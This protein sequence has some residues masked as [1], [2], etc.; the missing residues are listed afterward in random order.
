MRRLPLVLLLMAGALV[1][2]PG[3]ALAGAVRAAA[4]PPV[5]TSLPTIAGVVK[6]G[7]SLTAANG[8]WT[9]LAPIA[10]SYQWQ[11]CSTSGG[12]C[13]SIAKATNQNYV[14]SKDDVGKT[15]R[16]QVTGTN[17]DGKSQALSVATA[18]IAV[19]GN[20]PANTKQPNPSGNAT[21][22]K[23]IKVDNGNWSG[24]N[25]ITFSYQWQACT[26]V[27]GACK[28]I[29]GVTG[30]SFKIGAAQIGMLLR[31]T[32]TA[33][34]SAGKGSASSNLTLAVIAKANAPVNTTLPTISGL[35][36]VGRTLHL[37]T[38]N[39]TGVSANGFSYQWSRC[40]ADGTGCA[41]V[42]GATGQ[43]YGVR[44]A[45][46]RMAIR[47]VVTATNRNGSMS[48][49]S[50]ASV[51]TG[52]LANL[53]FKF[54]SV[55]RSGHEVKGPHGTSTRAAGHFSA[56]VTGQ[57]LTWT[58]RFHHLTGRPTVT[59][60]NKGVRHANGPAFKSLCRYRHCASPRHGTLRLTASQLDAMKRGR[61]YV[62]IHTMKNRPGEIRGQ[63]L[64]VR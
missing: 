3:S 46:F 17:A 51:I 2:L 27:P 41:N 44:Q 32:V 9:G 12:S 24:L 28:D 64:M 58:L 59:T 18:S 61:A 16:V 45:D 1:V 14:A 22:G 30:S 52:G 57:T 20:A 6:Q 33:T 25:P 63:I 34:N 42:F 49:Q 21:E 38:G 13:G 5:N 8:T 31:A 62:N 48:A 4:S 10:Y 29:D 43:N 56:K 19:N 36:A 7:E 26:A 15:I 53:T 23:T 50:A 60:L 39:W 55:L 11:R 35:K 54:T 40:N 37:S 47:G